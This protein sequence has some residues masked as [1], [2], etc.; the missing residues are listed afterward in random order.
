MLCCVLSKYNIVRKADCNV[1]NDLQ[2]WWWGKNVFLEGVKSCFSWAVQFSA[3]K[4]GGH[5]IDRKRRASALTPVTTI[6]SRRG[7]RTDS[8]DQSG[9]QKS[10]DSCRAP[11][12]D[13]PSHGLLGNIY[14]FKVCVFLCFWGQKN[15]KKK[16][17]PCLKESVEPQA[18]LHPLSNIDIRRSSTD[19]EAARD[20]HGRTLNVER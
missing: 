15:W 6:R 5:E 4:F 20:Y 8:A 3:E 12:A 10:F 14:P 18:P 17:D 13:V 2:W 11:S 7:E 16:H 1:C 19:A 9:D